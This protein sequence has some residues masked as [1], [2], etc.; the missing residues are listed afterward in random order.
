MSHLTQ[1]LALNPVLLQLHGEM[2]ADWLARLPRPGA[3]VRES[4][5]DK[6]E[7]PGPA[8]PEVST[9][10]SLVKSGEHGGCCPHGRT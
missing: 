1:S 4:A 10:R 6:Q 5:P 9:D 7:T 8:S 3:P 2:Y